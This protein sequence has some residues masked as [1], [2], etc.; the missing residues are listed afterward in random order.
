ML[1]YYLIASGV[2]L[3]ALL[4]GT[5]FV[6][7]GPALRVATVR[8]TGTPSPPRAEA[9]STLDPGGVQGVA[10]WA[11][12]ALPECFR[13]ERVA[14]GPLAFVRAQ[15]PPGARQ[16]AAGTVVRA[17]DCTLRV[18]AGTLGVERGNVRLSLPTPVR[19]LLAGRLLAVLRRGRS[20]AELRVYRPATGDWSVSAAP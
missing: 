4:L 12:S 10:A 20:T 3:G 14:R 9:A 15:L 2:V 6:H 8:A 13:Q 7:R 16:L 1:R 5:L 11:L 18:G 17:G 19:T